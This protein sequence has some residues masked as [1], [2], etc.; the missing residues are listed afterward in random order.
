MSRVSAFLLG[1]WDFLV[2]EDW[3]TAVGVAMTLGVTALLAQAGSPAWFV[4]PVA[5]FGL[6]AQ[7]VRR[8]AREASRH[9]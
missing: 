9:E 2:G 4:V 7:S 8:A 5:V 6:L 1:V 3:R